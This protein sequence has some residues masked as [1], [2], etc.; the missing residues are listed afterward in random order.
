MARIFLIGDQANRLQAALTNIY[1][2]AG[3]F[4]VALNQIGKSYDRLETAGLTYEQNV[5]VIVQRASAAGWIMDLVEQALKEVQDA[6]M[7]RLRAELR[8]L[9]IAAA[10]DPF[11]VCR[12]TGSNVMVDRADLRRH[13]RAMADPHGKRLLVVRGPRRSGRTHTVQ[14]LS[15]LQ[16]QRGGFLLASID[17]EAFSR[18]AGMNVL[19]ASNTAPVQITTLAPHGFTSGNSVYINGVKGNSG[20]NGLWQVTVTSPTEFVLNGSQGNGVYVSSGSVKLQTPVEAW[21]VAESLV[22]LLGFNPALVAPAPTDAQWARW[23]LQFC[24]RFQ[25]HARLEQ[26]ARIPPAQVWIVIDAFHTVLLAQSAVDL[27]RELANRINTT[28]HDFRMI[29]LGFEDTLPA[30][31]G[32]HLEEEAIGAISEDEIIEFI[33]TALSQ[34]RVPLDDDHVAEIVLKLL[35]DAPPGDPE[36]LLKLG[37]AASRELQRVEKS[38]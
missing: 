10:V 19:E 34:M 6:D 15:Y 8:P 4:R 28:L 17:L 1:G 18:T 32:N 26:D 38:R 22:D 12:L 7:L 9:V 3:D 31:V 5:L 35:N 21:H 36:F 29:L 11:L 25:G 30:Q 23:V 37:T 33:G 2:A 13:L 14:L 24:N 20:A 27:I 16:Q